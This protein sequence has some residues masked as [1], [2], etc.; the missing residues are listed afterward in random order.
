MLVRGNYKYTYYTDERPTLFDTKNDPRELVDLA[1]DS[2]Y[3]DVVADFEKLLRSIVDPEKTA[4]R[5]KRDLGLIGE[6]GEDYT[7]TLSV[8]DLKSDEV[9]Y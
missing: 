6:N 2:R 7:K 4:F 3:D 9:V 5:A 8:D 1:K